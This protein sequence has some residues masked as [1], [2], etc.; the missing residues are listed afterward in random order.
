MT[1][2]YPNSSFNPGYTYLVIGG[3]LNHQQIAQQF[4]VRRLEFDVQGEPQAYV[5]VPISIFNRSFEVLVYEPLTSQQDLA[6]ALANTL[7]ADR[8]L[9]MWEAG[10]PMSPSMGQEGAQSPPHP[11]DAI[12]DAGR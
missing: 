11:Q 6:A 7:L 5:K 4:P 8:A 12:E 9:P 10:V 2:A 1:S 3:P